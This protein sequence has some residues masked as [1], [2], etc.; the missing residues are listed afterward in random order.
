[1]QKIHEETSRAVPAGVPEIVKAI[2]NKVRARKS[3]PRVLD[4]NAC[5]QVASTV[6]IDTV[7]V[8]TEGV[9]ISTHSQEKVVAVLPTIGFIDLPGPLKDGSSMVIAMLIASVAFASVCRCCHS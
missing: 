4:C 2:E 5:L 6:T 3:G 1:V 9:P 7:T 8:V